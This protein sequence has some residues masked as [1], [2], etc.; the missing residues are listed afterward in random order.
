MSY[1]LL[2]AISRRGYG[3]TRPGESSARP[4]GAK[5]G[6]LPQQPMAPSGA[7][8]GPREGSTSP[9]PEAEKPLQSP[10]VPR[11]QVQPQPLDAKVKAP[12]WRPDPGGKPGGIPDPGPSGPLKPLKEIETKQQAAD[13]E[14]V[15][16]A[17]RNAVKRA[18]QAGTRAVNSGQKAIEKGRRDIGERAIAAGNR[19]LDLVAQVILGVT[20]PRLQN[21]ETLVSQLKRASADAEGAAAQAESVPEPTP[22]P[23][24]TQ[25]TQPDPTQQTQTTTTVIPDPTQTT[26]TT[27][28]PTAE[29][30]Q[31]TT[32]DQL[33]KLLLDQQQQPAW[34]PP[35]SGPP[36]PPPPPPSGGGW[37]DPYAALF[38]QSE[39]SQESAPPELDE[40]YFENEAMAEALVAPEQAKVAEQLE[41]MSEEEAVEDEAVMGSDG[42]PFLARPLFRGS[43]IKV[44]HGGLAF[45]ALAVL[46]ALA[47]EAA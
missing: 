40:T 1:E 3:R 43:P 4:G 11:D 10:W 5:P 22:Q 30:E 20:D 14:K 18:R 6:E 16:N 37:E 42:T 41:E 17:A 31:Q 47:E 38:A 32:L 28:T 24:Q 13:R 2:G 39:P 15:E 25:T 35:D 26:T 7:A 27:T 34:G 12:G 46:V 36:P 8:R 9:R 33:R 19:A 29:Q 21:L 23:T 44:W 45:A